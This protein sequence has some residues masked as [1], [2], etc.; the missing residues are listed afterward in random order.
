[1]TRASVGTTTQ[2]CWT[3]DGDSSRS[4]FASQFAPVVIPMKIGI[5]EDPIPSER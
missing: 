3:D 1:M 2:S 4:G 5:S